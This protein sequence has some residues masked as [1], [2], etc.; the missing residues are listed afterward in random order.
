[1]RNVECGIDARLVIPHSEFRIPHSRP[2]PTRVDGHHLSRIHPLLRV[3]RAAHG[4]HRSERLRV[5]DQG[6]V[7]QLVEPDPV[8]AG[9]RPARRDA[10]L[11]DRGARGVHA[12]PEAGD[13]GSRG[14]PRGYGKPSPARMHVGPTIWGAGERMPR[15]IPAETASPAARS[16][17]K[18][19]RRVRTARG[20]GRSRTAIR[21]AIPKFPSEPTNNPTTSG[22][23]G[24]PPGL[25]SSTM[26]PS[27]STTSRANTCWAVTPYL[28]QCGPPA[29]SAT[30]PP[31]VHAVWLDG[32]GA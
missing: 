32:S 14:G 5:E 30:L 4:A 28:R 2:L 26:R 12:G 3:P 29:F 10:R 31:M 11:H 1:M 13:A 23:H 22:P 17:A 15:A 20:N 9:D 27:A 18:A 16:E 7:A 6:H 24:S 21:V 8:L 25:P 19:A